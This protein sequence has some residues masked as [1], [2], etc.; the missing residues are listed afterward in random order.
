MP[1][2]SRHR[3]TGAAFAVPN[4]NGVRCRLRGSGSAGSDR[5]AQLLE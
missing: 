2:W 1:F 5:L 4:S 3:L